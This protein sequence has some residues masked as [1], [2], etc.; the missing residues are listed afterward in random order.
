MKQV[1]LAAAFVLSAFQAQ[2]GV[3][4]FGLPDLTFPDPLPKPGIS[5]QGCVPTA[6]P[7]P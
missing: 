3:P 1:F 4:G 6:A 7:C 5:T 2:A